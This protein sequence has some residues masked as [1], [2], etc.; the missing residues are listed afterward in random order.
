MNKS[1]FLI[2]FILKSIKEKKF[3][4]FLIIFSISISCALFFAS[5]S[6]AL[7]MKKIYLIMRRSWVGSSDFYITAN[8]KSPSWY[9]RL[10]KDLKLDD[11]FEYIVGGIIENGVKYKESIDETYNL[12]LLAINYDDLQRFNPI[13][14]TAKKNLFPFKDKKIIFDTIFLKKYN[15]Q[16]GETIDL[17]IRDNKYKFVISAAAEPSG[18]FTHTDAGSSKGVIPIER[19]TSIFGAKGRVSIAFIK[20]KD[21]IEKSVILNQLSEIYNRYNVTQSISEWEIDRYSKQISAPF[22][23]MTIFV[24]FMT[25]FIIYSSFKIITTERLPIIGTMRSIGATKK[26]TD[27]I[28]ILESIIYGIIGGIIGIFLGFI[29][30]YIMTY[31][32]SYNPWS[33]GRFNVEIDFSYLYLILSFLLAILLSFVGSIVPIIRISKIQIKDIILNKVE[34]KYKEK[35]KRHFIG[36]LLL[37]SSTIIPFLTPKKLT[38]VIDLSCAIA[39]F[40]G[41]ILII[42]KLTSLFIKIFEKNYNLFFGNI[43]ILSAKNLRENKNILNSISLLAIGISSLLVINIINFSV[44]K[45]LLDFYSHA[46]Y[47]ASYWLWEA[48]RNRER[49]IRSI[50]GVKDTYGI[51]K[52]RD[53]GV[54]GFKNKIGN[55]YGINKKFMDY[56]D[57]GI[58][59][60]AMNELER[61]RNI[62]ATV[63]IKDR[64]RFK[65]GDI[66]TLLSEK[67]ERQYKIIG[68][69]NSLMDNGDFVLINERYL[70]LDMKVEFYDTIYIKTN[71]NPD[72]FVKTFKKRLGFILSVNEMKKNIKESNKQIFI[73]LNGFS[74]LTLIIG[75]FGILNNFII[76]FIQRRRYLAIFRSIGMSKKQIV[77]MV[78]L[79]A[80][81]GGLIGGITAVFSGLLILQIVPFL[82]NV[83]DQSIPLHYSFSR[84]IIFMILG[85]IITLIGSIS[86]ALKSSKLNIIESIKYE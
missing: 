53:I 52:V 65:K 40:I 23:I 54:K 17:F 47:D 24:L 9:F 45:E 27:I 84:F 63:T 7:T 79:E 50:N 29:I 82:L 22:K 76:S 4:F 48:N 77:L 57:F 58:K 73:I 67:G 81:A 80:L 64:F 72:K 19:L 35:N 68:F 34:V 43:G 42:P 33:G 18:F 3:R 15:L 12:S 74:I 85:M 25:I 69:F 38:L 2:K 41:I 83:I 62:L 8:R 78:F 75:I 55:V 44:D 39:I 16:V 1:M 86:P 59:E 28:L 21:K 71:I 10:N 70:K 5:N 30:L 61:N 49:V 37:I 14:I 46:K 26:N 60:E 56:W 31:I 6:L 36:I 32:K 51:Y 13:K 11:K 20:S 66:I